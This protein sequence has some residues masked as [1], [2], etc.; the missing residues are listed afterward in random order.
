MPTYTH[1]HGVGRMLAASKPLVVPMHI[2]LVDI[3]IKAL[4]RVS[5]HVWKGLV[6]SFLN[7]PLES[8]TVSTTFDALPKLR[9]FLQQEI[10]GKI[11]EALLKDLPEALHQWSKILIKT[12]MISSSAP[13]SL[14]RESQPIS[15]NEPIILKKN[16]SRLSLSMI[17]SI[18]DKS[19]ESYEFFNYSRSKSPV[20]L[21]CLLPNLHR[22]SDIN[23]PIVF[24]RS[25]SQTSIKGSFSSSF[26]AISRHNIANSSANDTPMNN[27]LTHHRMKSWLQQGQHVRRNA[28]RQNLFYFS[29]LDTHGA[30]LYFGQQE[31]QTSRGLGQ[32][33]DLIKEDEGHDNSLEPA[34]I[35]S[36]SSSLSI[37]DHLPPESPSLD[38]RS[39]YSKPLAPSTP[40]HSPLFTFSLSKFNKKYKIDVYK[41]TTAQY[42]NANPSKKFS[43]NSK[44][45]NQE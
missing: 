24:H 43:I 23:S 14:K 29:D 38:L 20:G 26:G 31:I 44:S 33:L 30:G 28:T 2:R 8:I 9:T 15:Q 21:S 36:R 27:T 39:T 7:D 17:S 4:V 42:P 18:P 16:H 34:T 45:A 41:C 19:E 35:H 1:H 3:K 22:T 40:L 32:V 10:E 13:G 37:S 5:F 6:I 12:I 25:I 11:R